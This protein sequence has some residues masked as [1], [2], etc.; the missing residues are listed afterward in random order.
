MCRL[1]SIEI[2]RPFVFPLLYANFLSFA[3]FFFEVWATATFVKT[4]PVRAAVRSNIVSK[5]QNKRN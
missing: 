2:D 3:T 5:L 4:N 1:F